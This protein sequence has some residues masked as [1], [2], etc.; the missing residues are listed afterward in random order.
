MR[1]PG[2]RVKERQLIERGRF[3]VSVE[4][5]LVYPDFNPGEPGYEAETVEFL[6]EV[7]ERADREDL[8][9]LRSHGRVFELVGA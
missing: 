1:L 8:D 2:K 6:R 9:W 5:D 4:V 7:A 3:V